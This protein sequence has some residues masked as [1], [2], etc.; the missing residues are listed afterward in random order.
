MGKDQYALCLVP[1]IDLLNHAAQPAVSL[2]LQRQEG[3]VRERRG[4]L[5]GLLLVRC[6]KL[7]RCQLTTSSGSGFKSASAARPCRKVG[8]CSTSCP[9]ARLTMVSSST[10]DNGAAICMMLHPLQSSGFVFLSDAHRASLLTHLAAGLAG[11]QLFNT[12]GKSAACAMH[13]IVCSAKLPCSDTPAKQGP[14][15]SL[16]DTWSMHCG[17]STV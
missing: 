4:A 15:A 3:G 6:S 12:Y 9:L 7:L 17:R 10:L 8:A 13:G 2:L 1:G 14:G 5:T 11:Q 16:S